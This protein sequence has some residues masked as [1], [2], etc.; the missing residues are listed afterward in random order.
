MV[1][2]WRPL[3]SA[4]V[5]VTRGSPHGRPTQVRLT[6]Q[7]SQPNSTVFCDKCKRT[8]QENL[9]T[10]V[11]LADG[12]AWIIFNL[13]QISLRMQ[14]VEIG[15]NATMGHMQRTRTTVFGAAIMEYV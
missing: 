4:V 2:A 8:Q 7:Q 9:P 6:A 1:G 10:Q 12:L 5:H 14:D 15:M 13:L 11:L 3:S